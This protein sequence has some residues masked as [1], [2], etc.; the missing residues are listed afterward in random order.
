[1]HPLQIR[2]YDP[3][4]VEAAQSMQR[5]FKEIME[6]AKELQGDHGSVLAAF[7]RCQP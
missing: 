4:H 1:M 6:R 2:R 5:N 7:G 3:R